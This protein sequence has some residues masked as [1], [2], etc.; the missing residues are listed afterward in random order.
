MWSDGKYIHYRDFVLSGDLKLKVLE[1]SDSYGVRNQFDFKWKLEI[2]GDAD[3][4]KGYGFPF[5]S[6]GLMLS[7]IPAIIIIAYHY[8]KKKKDDNQISEPF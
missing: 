7:P 6:I 2:E 4:T 1:V 8:F 5:W 3:I